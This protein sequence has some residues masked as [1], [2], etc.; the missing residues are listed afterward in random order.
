MRRIFIDETVK[1]VAQYYADH[2]FERHIRRDFVKPNEGLIAFENEIRADRGTCP[3]WRYYADY[4][5]KL[6]THL[7]EIVLLKP[8]E[9]GVWHRRYFG[10]PA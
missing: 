6:R 8:S 3:L 1:E 5:E 7:D 9:F 2:L 4:V 10:S